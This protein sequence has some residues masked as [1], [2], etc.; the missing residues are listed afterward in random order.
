MLAALPIVAAQLAI[1]ALIG[2]AALAPLP[3]RQRELLLPAAP[4]LGAALC[5]VVLSSTAYLM[6][7]RAGL[8]VVVALSAVLLAAGTA[9][10]RR[11]W[12]T[13]ARSLWIAGAVLALSCIGASVALLPAELSGGRPAAPGFGSHDIYFYTAESTWLRDHSIT[14]GPD[15]GAAPGEGAP[16]AYGPLRAA[17]DAPLRIGQPMVHAALD[18]ALDTLAVE[19]ITPLISLWVLL[20]G[21]AAFVAARLVT[22][23]VRISLVACVAVNSS[24]ILL[25][26]ALGQNVDGVLGTA[27]ALLTIGTALAAMARRLSPWPA[28]LALAGLAGVYTEYGLFVGPTVLGALALAH[29]RDWRSRLTALAATGALAIAIAPMIWWRA[30][31]ALRLDRAS[32]G[33]DWASPFFSDGALAALARFVGTASWRDQPGL[34]WFMWLVAVALGA[35]AV[36]AV[37]LGPYRGAWAGALLVIAPYIAVQTADRVGYLQMRSI[38]LAGPIVLFIAVLGIGAA[39]SRWRSAGQGRHRRWIVEAVTI[40]ALIAFAA[41]NLH[42]AAATIEPGF[43]RHRSFDD[44]YLEAARWVAEHGGHEG[45][46][47]TVLSG[48]VISQTWLAYALRD[49]DLV[50]YAALRTDY[51]NKT[52]YADGLDDRYLLIAPGALWDGEDGAV[53]KSN[54]KFTLVDREGHDLVAAVPFDQQRWPQIVDASGET[55]APDL[56]RVLVV[57][58]TEGPR[59]VNL[60]L[61]IDRAAAGRIGVTGDIATPVRARVSDPELHRFTDVTVHLAGAGSAGLTLDLW[62]DGLPST[63]TITLAGVTLAHSH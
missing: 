35:G 56:A 22:G 30:L 61:V 28:A 63:E 60:R 52:A 42:S 8:L 4:V 59:R 31:G 20:V 29:W 37:L 1:L 27:L 46:D 24:A 62:A 15:A 34:G 26:Q 11:P 57:T 6:S 5:A 51:L 44:D 47:V 33:A 2:W 25:S 10:G 48:E 18:G 3:Q 32:G 21:Q 17:L 45:R 16:P 14:E 54:E 36:L 50:A 43:P 23:S 39:V 13:P 41:V 12:R 58:G 49:L 55:V 19:T 7:A 53:V 9:M 38:Q 40:P